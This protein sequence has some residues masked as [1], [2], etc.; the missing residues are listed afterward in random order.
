MPEVA[1]RKCAKRSGWLLAIPA[2]AF[3]PKC[4]MCLLAYFALAETAVWRF[5]GVIWAV[6]AVAFML[7]MWL[8]RNLARR[9]ARLSDRQREDALK[10]PLC[11]GPPKPAAYF[12]TCLTK[13]SAIM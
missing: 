3:M 8:M 12:P 9:I 13:K 1:C 2:L 10:S 7:L 4:P 11:A 5:S 6:G